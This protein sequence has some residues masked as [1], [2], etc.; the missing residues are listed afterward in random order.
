M[1]YAGNMPP[2]NIK[3]LREKVLFVCSQEFADNYAEF[4]DDNST[5][6]MAIDWL[7]L[8]ARGVEG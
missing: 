8:F 7:D 4:A 1:V 5:V 6:I 3:L 2:D